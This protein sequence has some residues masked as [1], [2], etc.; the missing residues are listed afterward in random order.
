[1]GSQWSLCRWPWYITKLGSWAKQEAPSGW[2]C[3]CVVFHM[4]SPIY[5]TVIGTILSHGDVLMLWRLMLVF[6][7]LV[8]VEFTSLSPSTLSACR[9]EWAWAQRNTLGIAISK[10]C[11]RN[12]GSWE[13][14]KIAIS[15]FIPSSFPNFLSLSLTIDKAM[16]TIHNVRSSRRSSD[17]VKWTCRVTYLFFCEHYTS[18]KRFDFFGS[19]EGPVTTG[20]MGD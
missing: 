15:G 14:K 18:Q 7:I 4:S 13:S 20:H 17:L 11:D 1:M 12:G 3:W 5:C 9:D 8:C 6:C 16:W 2:W 19:L 10:S